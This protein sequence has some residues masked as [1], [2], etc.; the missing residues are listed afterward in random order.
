MHAPVDEVD[1]GHPLSITHVDAARAC[2]EG[3]LVASLPD[4][5]TIAAAQPGDGDGLVWNAKRVRRSA[6]PR[7]R[8][9]LP[10]EEPLRC[11]RAEDAP[12]CV[13]GDEPL[14]PKVWSVL[15]GN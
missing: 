4:E 6:T 12:G 14:E 11:E 10:G 7:L 5:P 13:V 9:L 15:L 8:R 1:V 2:A 3:S